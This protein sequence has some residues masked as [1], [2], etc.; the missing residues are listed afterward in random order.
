MPFLHWPMRRV[1]CRACTCFEMDRNSMPEPALRWS[2][3]RSP[4]LLRRFLPQVTFLKLAIVIN[5]LL[6]TFSAGAQQ[7]DYNTQIK[8]KPSAIGF[9]AASDHI[10]FVSPNGNDA[11]DGLS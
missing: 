5:L 9:P 4:L 2:A 6:S 7:I 11:N 10:Q 3:K 1:R 8:N